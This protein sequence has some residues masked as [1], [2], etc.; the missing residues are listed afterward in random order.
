MSGLDQGRA[1]PLAGDPGLTNQ[2][3][4]PP[5][6]QLSECFQDGQLSQYLLVRFSSRMLGILGKESSFFFFFAEVAQIMGCKFG[7][8]MYPRKPSENEE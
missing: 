3:I 1:S 8:A 5:T 6:P 4:L 7:A 2:S